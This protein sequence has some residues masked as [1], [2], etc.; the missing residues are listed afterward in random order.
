M[1]KDLLSWVK[2]DLK[3]TSQLD[4]PVKYRNLV[5][6]IKEGIPKDIAGAYARVRACLV[7][8]VIKPEEMETVY[9]YDV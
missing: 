2:S 3:K 7:P 5:Q 4:E 8:E 9:E 1:P 6:L